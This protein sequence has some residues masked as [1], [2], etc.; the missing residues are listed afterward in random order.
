MSST[1]LYKI[2]IEVKKYVYFTIY[3]SFCWI[4]I[5]KK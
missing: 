5:K 3:S 1:E 4:A 2:S